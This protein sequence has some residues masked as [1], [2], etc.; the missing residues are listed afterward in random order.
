MAEGLINFLISDDAEAKKARQE[1]NYLIVPM[2]NPDGIF[3][4]TSR[5]NM[6]MEDLNNIW[7]DDEKVQPEVTGIKNWVES[8]T[9]NGNEVDLFID[10]HNHSQFHRY[11]VLIFQDNN[12]DSLVT[13]MNKHWP[14]R[15]WHSEFK[16]S[17]CDYFFQKGIPGGTIE[18][19]QSHLSDGKYLKIEDYH[20]FGKGTVLALNEF[21]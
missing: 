21:F 15:L 18:L 2:M 17:S 19:S 14:I 20:L 12:L 3:N 16:G 6:Q 11:N 9:A 13:I 4:G 7:L 5:Y 1:F 10:I 8:W